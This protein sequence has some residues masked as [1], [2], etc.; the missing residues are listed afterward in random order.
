MLK[1]IGEKMKN[2]ISIFLVLALSLL[3]FAC[4][5]SKYK[6]LQEEEVDKEQKYFAESKATDILNS[7]KSG[8]YKELGDEST[9]SMQKGLSAEKQNQTQDHVSH[10]HVE[11]N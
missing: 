6:T 5:E 1:I 11:R 7:M 2:Y 8:Q 10:F 4:T 3:F 9:L